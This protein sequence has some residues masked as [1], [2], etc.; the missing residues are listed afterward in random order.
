[1]SFARKPWPRATAY[2]TAL[3]LLAA[4]PPL[5]AQGIAVSNSQKEAALDYL[6]ALA[7]NDPQAI[8]LT[9]HPDD[10]KALR[11]RILALLHQEAKKGES[12]VRVRLFGAGRQLDEI[13][14]LTDTG[15][16]AALADH[17][18][19][20]G[21]E[22]ESLE[23][24]AAVSDRDGRIEVLVRGKQPSERG[25]VRVVELVALKPFGKGWKAALPSEVEAQIEDLIDAR[26]GSAQEHSAAALRGGRGTA[27][28]QAGIVT[29]LDTSEKLLAEGKCAQYYDEQMSPN[30]RRVT[31][32]KALE[33]LIQSCKS[34]LGTREMLLATL[35]IVRTLEPKYEYDGQRAVYD[36]AG[37]GLPFD[38]F[39][40]ERIE[41][42]WYVAE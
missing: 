1:M 15:F 26:Q 31:G 40:L 36:L 42:A 6:Q 28:A 25:K 32:R 39:T 38:H 9:L 7:S 22:F 27:P 13:E 29:L 11:L 18:Y 4:V 30:F 24:L 41:R 21:R 35:R 20:P 23:G 17:L 19:L 33:A 16:Y 8:A 10:L 12:T 5:A 34:S 37:Q 3:L 2:V 14:H